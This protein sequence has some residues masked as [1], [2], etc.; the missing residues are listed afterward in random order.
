MLNTGDTAFLMMCTA[1]VWLMTPALAFFYGGLVRKT[2]ILTIMF[3]TFVCVGLVAVIW[4]LGGF[5][6]AFGPDIGQ[7]IGN[8]LTFFGMRGVGGAANARYAPTVPFVVFFA[9]QMMFAIIAPALSRA[10]LSAVSN[11]HHTSGLSYCGQCSS[12]YRSRIGF[13]AAASSLSWGSWT[14]LVD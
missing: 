11:S 4:V 2:D 6:L 13:G 12:I 10:L 5:S 1:M 8:P 14:S 3:Q 7:I 9:Y